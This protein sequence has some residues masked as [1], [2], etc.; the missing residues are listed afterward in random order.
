MK[1]K[2]SKTP[3]VIKI[4]SSNLHSE[5]TLP[6]YQVNRLSKNLAKEYRNTATYKRDMI[7]F[8]FKKL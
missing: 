3:M 1:K 2:E 8:E 4:T 6:E 7:T 5:L